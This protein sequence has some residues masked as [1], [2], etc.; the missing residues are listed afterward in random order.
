MNIC[1]TG[2]TGFVGAQL[3]AKLA[4]RE[5]GRDGAVRVTWRDRSRLEALAGIDVEPLEADVLDRQAMRNALD[6]CELLF[7]AAGMVASR[8]A[9]TVWE[10]NAVAPRIAVECAA[11]VGVRRV[12]LTSSVAAIGPAPSGRPADEREPDPR[13]ESG[14]IYAD[15]KREGERA[16]FAAGERLGVEVVAVNPAYVLGPPLNRSR[17]AE[18]STRIVGNYLRGRLPA[19]VDSFTNIV[20]VEDVAD[21]HLLAAE[22]GKPGERYILGGENLRWSAVI[23]QIASLSGR[24][25]PVLVMPPEIASRAALLRRVRL[26][27]LPLEGIRLMAPDWRYSSEKA[28]RE[29]SYAPR[30]AIETLRRT[31]D[32]YLALLESGRVAKGTR[33]PFDLMTAGV[34]LGD[35]LGLLKPLK[36]AGRVTGRKL[37]L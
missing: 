31:V 35:R 14:M 26:P 3:A 8:P 17:G 22:A 12:V 13:A 19:I 32:W 28:K 6:G 23:E 2:A 27:V 9:R 34:H 7:H 10:V 4:A 30:G 25:Y 1:V 5:S 18:T 37:V 11:D 36:A 21:G 24:E 33:R 15:A 29:L 16:A 20:D